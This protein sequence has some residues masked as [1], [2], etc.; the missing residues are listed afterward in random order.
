MHRIRIALAVLTAVT[1]TASAVALA[2]PEVVGIDRTESDGAPV[3]TGPTGQG[4]AAVVPVPSADQTTE[5]A[6]PLAEPDLRASAPAATSAA[7][8]PQGWYRHGHGR[9]V[10]AVIDTG[11]NVFHHEFDYRG[12]GSPDDQVVAWWDFTSAKKGGIAHPQPGQTWDAHVADPYDNHGHGTG[13]ASV[14]VGR[15]R[16]GQMQRAFAPGFPLAVAKVGN[17]DGAIEGDVAAAIRWAVDTVK[18]DVINVSIG[19]ITPFPAL[20]IDVDEA[21]QYARHSGVLVVFANGNGWL[22]LGLPGDPGW[23]SGYGF[24][25][26]ALAVGGSGA[27]DPYRIH[28]DPEV[29]APFRQTVAWANGGYATVAGTS[30][31]APL[32][33]GMAARL[34]YESMSFGHRGDPGYIETLLKRGA[35]DTQTPPQFEGYGVLDAI[36]FDQTLIHHAWAGKLP[37]RPT[38]DVSAVYVEKINGT[39]RDVWSNKLDGQESMLAL[40][41]IPPITDKGVIGPSSATGTSE[42]EVW[43]LDTTPGQVV[44]LN[45][46]YGAGAPV[47]NDLDLYVFAGTASPFFED[48]VVTRSTN[49]AGVP[50]SVTFVATGGSYT[51]VV[52]GWLVTTPKQ[53]H[54]LAGTTPIGLV[55]EQIVVHTFGFDL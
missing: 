48:Q 54:W 25:T 43:R 8:P 18:A 35:R 21:A 9:S 29:A 10:V 16:T 52:L 22:N 31:S 15:N 41:G 45:L 46:G 33:A 27:S 13:V 6:P 53:Y 28:T 44:T 34:K 49:P 32:V 14:A 20:L 17:R 11:V 39:L 42:A 3:A 24:S 4:P 36:A 1:L 5:V 47:P 37:P 30:F 40:T 2:A 12:A 7:A 26:H 23:A 55:G 38:P 19:T 51:V 50:E